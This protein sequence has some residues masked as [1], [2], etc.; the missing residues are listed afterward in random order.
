MNS[1]LSIAP[2]SSFK[3]SFAIQAAAISKGNET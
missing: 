1:K 2:L 3:E